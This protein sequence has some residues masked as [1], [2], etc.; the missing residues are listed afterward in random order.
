MLGI[1]FNFRIAEK[2]CI[3]FLKKSR[4]NLYLKH[5]LTMMSIRIPSE[6]FI[7]YGLHKYCKN[8]GE[9]DFFIIFS[10]M[11]K[12]FHHAFLVRKIAVTYC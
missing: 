9:K 2:G 10:T 4:E 12:K 11:D 8:K 7:V 6:K 1:C 5:F 3:F